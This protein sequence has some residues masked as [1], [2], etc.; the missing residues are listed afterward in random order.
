MSAWPPPAIAGVQLRTMAWFGTTAMVWLG[1]ALSE[2]RLTIWR[3]SSVDRRRPDRGVKSGVVWSG[4][5]CADR[6]GLSWLGV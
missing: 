2:W 4:P 1:T 6:S 5:R 3:S